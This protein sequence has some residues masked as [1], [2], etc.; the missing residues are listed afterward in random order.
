MLPTL[1]DG[2]P[3]AGDCHTFGHLS[4]AGMVRGMLESRS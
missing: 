3:P 2:A 4:D 1:T